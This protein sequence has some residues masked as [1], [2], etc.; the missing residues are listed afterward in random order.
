MAMGGVVATA[1]SAPDKLPA[2][3]RRML[4]EKQDPDAVP[5]VQDRWW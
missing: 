4:P 2:Q 3:V 5:F 1:V